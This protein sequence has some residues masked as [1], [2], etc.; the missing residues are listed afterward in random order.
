METAREKVAAKLGCSGHEIIFTSC[1]TESDNLA[2]RGAAMARRTQ[3]GSNRIFAARVE[4]HAVTKTIEQLEQHYGFRAEWLPVDAFGR[5]TAQAVEA[6]LTDDAALISVMY[7]SGPLELLPA[8][9][10]TVCVAG[11]PW[12]SWWN[13]ESTFCRIAFSECPASAKR[14]RYRPVA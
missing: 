1:G 6:A 11:S 5:V 9:K 14:L 2:L 12:N 8:E 7:A 13:A 10:N 3:N 4:H